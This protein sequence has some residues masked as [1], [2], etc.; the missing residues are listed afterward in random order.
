MGVPAFILESERRW[1]YFLEHSD[2]LESSWSIEQLNLSQA[3]RLLSFLEDDH[4][5]NAYDVESCRR[6]LER[7]TSTLRG[8]EGS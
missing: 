1:S 6:C 7:W 5:S 8:D 4:F 2:D 3:L